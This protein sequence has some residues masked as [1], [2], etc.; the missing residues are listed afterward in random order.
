MTKF[1]KFAALAATVLATTP[2][3]AVPVGVTGAPPSA[4][5]RII[6][7]LSLTSTGSLNFG[8]I[9]LN[10]VTANRTVA[11]SS[12]NVL[13]CGAGTTELQCSGTTSV[14]TY[15]VRGTNNQVV[16]IIKAATN[17]TNS[18]DSTTLSMTPT[19]AASVTLTNSGSP[20]FDFTIGG[21]IVIGAATT[22]GVYS[23]VVDVRVDYQ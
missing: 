4:T 18:T 6:R 11:L 8:T 10:S 2:A 5:A 14:P 7:P 3:L 17:L 22:D 15:N 16:T 12:G 13:D 19:G 1:V 21:T 23:G 20:G 9:V